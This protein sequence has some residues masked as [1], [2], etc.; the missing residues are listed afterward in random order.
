MSYLMMKI[1]NWDRGNA[2]VQPRAETVTKQF[3]LKASDIDRN[4]GV[5]GIG[6]DQFVVMVTPDAAKQ[7]LAQHVDNTIKGKGPFVEG[8]FS[9]PAIGTMR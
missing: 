1:T 4:F 2:T 8:P 3:N 6:P 5:V 7:M 9:A